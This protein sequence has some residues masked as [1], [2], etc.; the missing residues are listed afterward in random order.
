MIFLL[1]TEATVLQAIMPTN[2]RQVLLQLQRFP[3][4]ELRLLMALL[5]QLLQLL[6]MHIH[7]TALL[8][9]LMVISGHI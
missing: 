5:I 6:P 8:S 1:A 9:N 7:P 3:L 2:Q 4:M